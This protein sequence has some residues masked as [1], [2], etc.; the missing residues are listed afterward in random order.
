MITLKKENGEVIHGQLN[1]LT[2]KLDEV[3][4]F[5]DEIEESLNFDVDLM[6]ENAD[7]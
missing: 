3:V 6:F 7:N 1:D 4:D 5:Y 2:Y